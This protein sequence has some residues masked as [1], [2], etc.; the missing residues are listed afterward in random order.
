MTRTVLTAACVLLAAS[1]AFGASPTLD[2][3]SQGIEIA[4]AGG[5]PLVETAV[6]DAVYQ[7]VTRADLGDVRV[8]N[9][10]GLPVPHAFCSSPST[11]EPSITD[12]SLPVFELREAP[13]ANTGGSRIE[14]Q[15]A[16]GTQV[17]VLEAGSEQPLP[18]NGRIHIID[19]RESDDPHPR[20]QLR[21]GEPG[22][23]LASAGQHRGQ[24]RS[25]SMARAGA[26]EH[27]AARDAR[28]SAIATRAHRAAAA[29][30]STTCAC[31][32][33]TAVRRSRSMA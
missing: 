16:G 17:N 21:L 14:V 11:E 6:P 24:R 23:R 27:A 18:A 26:G 33:R 22:R 1:S 10:E 25:G 2:D 8:F 20:D 7:A 4:T 19:A 12:Q 31:S 9:A 3:Y 15:T 13:P 32:E 5:L 28:R 30:L 29:I